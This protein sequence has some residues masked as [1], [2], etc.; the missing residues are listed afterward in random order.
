MSTY[1]LTRCTCAD[2]GVERLCLAPAGVRRR[3]VD[4]LAELAELVDSDVT[5]AWAVA[6]AG[7]APLPAGKDMRASG[8]QG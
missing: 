8:G 7:P 1:V 4:P 3:F 6:W 2:D 5:R